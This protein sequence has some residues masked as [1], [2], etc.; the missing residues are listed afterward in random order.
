MDGSSNFITKWE[1]DTPA[2]LV[3]LD[4]M[5]KNLDTMAQY[6]RDKGINLRPHSKTYKAVPFFAWMQL[7]AGAIGITVSKLTEAETLAASGVNSILIA[8]QIVGRTKIKRLANLCAY[9]DTIAA[10]DCLENIEM[11]S[12]IASAQ[13]VKVG[14]LVEVDIGN[15]RCGADPDESIELAQA[16]TR[17]NGVEFRGIMGYDG[18]L[19]FMEDSEKKEL[20]SVEAYKKLASVKERLESM[21]IPV[22]I[23]SGSGSGT[24]KSATSV[25]SLTELQAGTYIFNDTTY[26]S[27]C[28]PEYECVLSIMATV[29]SKKQRPGFENMAILNLGKKC[30]SL[31]YGFPP[32]K[33]HKGEIYSMPQE[34]CRI[35]LSPDNPDVKVGDPIE[36]YVSDSNETFNLYEHVYLV[37]GDLVVGK[38]EIYSHGKT[39]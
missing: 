33:S 6:C 18:H 19:V 1:L 2:L 16:I 29:I 37:R 23:V 34:H 21:G 7:K 28:L 14:L 30:I 31:N 32:V 25:K 5:K 11:I 38:I 22:E 24:Y 17:L 26:K 36:I 13:G 4:A 8:N 3:D 35:R 20:L 9:T 27:K 39:T 15:N 10:T 12:E